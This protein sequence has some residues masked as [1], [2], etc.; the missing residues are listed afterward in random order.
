[1]CD[2]TDVPAPDPRSCVLASEVPNAECIAWD[3]EV[4]KNHLSGE[5][6]AVEHAEALHM[7][8]NYAYIS[9][10]GGVRTGWVSDLLHW[11]VWEVGGKRFIFREYEDGW[12]SRWLQDLHTDFKTMAISAPW[13]SVPIEFVRFKV[14]R[15]GAGLNCF[16]PLEVVA[17]ACGNLEANEYARTT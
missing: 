2:T 4:L 9:Y 7:V 14:S 11:S 8:G 5:E 17:Q 10:A 16:W 13:T 1:M 12:E 6:R 15:P 3:G